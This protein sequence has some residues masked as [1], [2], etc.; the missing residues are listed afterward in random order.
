MLVTLAILG[1]LLAIAAM[2]VRAPAVRLA[3]DSVHGFVQEGRFEAIRTNRP[4]IVDVDADAGTLALRRG[5][6]A[7]TIDCSTGRAD[8]RTL[9]L[10]EYRN[11][12]PSAD[13]FPFVWLPTGRPRSC[14]AAPLP[15]DGVQ[16]VLRDGSKEATVRVN[17]GGEVRIE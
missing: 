2:N 11:V 7:D 17:A 4:V 15:L 14:S 16:V 3:A 13:G 5:D 10:G 9:A 6:N 8:A 1:T 12:N